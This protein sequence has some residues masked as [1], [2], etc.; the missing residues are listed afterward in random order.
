MLV[1]HDEILGASE[2]SDPPAA[3][4]AMERHIQ[5]IIDASILT[6][7]GAVHGVVTRELTAEELSYTT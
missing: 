5:T 1:E 4:Q 6:M 2:R 3:K 7:D